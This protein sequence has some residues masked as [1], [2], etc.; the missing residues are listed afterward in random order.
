M[1]SYDSLHPAIVHAPLVLLPFAVLLALVDLVRP[2][3]HLRYVALAL[4]FCGVLGAFLATQTGGAAREHARQLGTLPRIPASGLVPSLLG[5]NDL[6]HTHSSL[7][8][9]VELFYGFLLA[10]EIVLIA[11]RLP[12]GERYRRG[13][14]L[15]ATQERL[16]RSVW[17]VAA[18][19]GFSLIYATGYYGGQLVYDHGVGVQSQQRATPPP[20]AR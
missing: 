7:G 13:V 11:L 6:M 2:A 16:A 14:T 10:V 1:P 8:D 17:V 15:S 3:L 12:H 20:P 5:T 18:L 19:A 9:D 4:L